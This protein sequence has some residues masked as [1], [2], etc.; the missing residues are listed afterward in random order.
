MNED[1]MTWQWHVGRL[2][3]SEFMQF[4]ICIGI[5]TFVITIVATINI[6]ITITKNIVITI[7]ILTIPTRLDVLSDLI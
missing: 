4:A 2:H 5:C 1:F 6:T 7:T 3:C